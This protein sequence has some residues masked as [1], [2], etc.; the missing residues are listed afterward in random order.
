MKCKYY[1][2]ITADWARFRQ[3]QINSGMDAS[4]IYS[5]I[6]FNKTNYPRT[7]CSC[8][9]SGTGEESTCPHCGGKILSFGDGYFNSTR[10][11][12][13]I[14]RDSDALNFEECSVFVDYKGT[15]CALCI[16]TDVVGQYD[17]VKKEWVI[18]SPSTSGRGR[19]F[20]NG[21]ATKV[22]DHVRKEFPRFCELFVDTENS[23]KFFL[24]RALNYSTAALAVYTSYPDAFSDDI[25][26]KYP[27]SS[28]ILL[29]SAAT[30]EISG[31]TKGVSINMC[32]DFIDSWKAI[33]LPDELI[34]IIEIATSN[35]QN[36]GMTTAMFSD[37]F[38][39]FLKTKLGVFFLS[40]IRHGQVDAYK[41][42]NFS[43]EFAN[44][45]DEYG[46]DEEVL[47]FACREN[48]DMFADSGQL[49]RE[50]AAR[51]SWLRENHIP[52][53]ENSIRTKVFNKTWNMANF[54]KT[55]VNTDIEKLIQEDPLKLIDRI[56]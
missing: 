39:K 14:Y 27:E 23:P 38:A 19:H 50:I 20:D 4:E 16:V 5:G 2:T 48:A 34:P 22:V 42:A 40:R 56:R 33:G 37:K 55:L 3:V 29:M 7:F 11:F 28:K 13:D 10:C 24:G 51:C 21:Y 49:V 17:T 30:D 18:Y 25:I 31:G 47:L 26:K 36:L 53:D 32:N 6:S 44:I 41:V 52:I 9:Y 46:V 35:C 45:M 1:A 43:G 15:D 54:R 12:I 8:G